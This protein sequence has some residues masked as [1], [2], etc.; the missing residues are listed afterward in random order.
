M[1]R[2]DT[3][4]AVVENSIFDRTNTNWAPRSKIEKYNRDGKRILLA[5]QNVQIL[6]VCLK[7]Y[8]QKMAA[9]S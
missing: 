6:L 1:R 5:D 2:T 9:Y 8:C 7:R 3:P 4:T